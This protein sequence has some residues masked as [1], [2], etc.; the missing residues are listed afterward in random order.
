MLHIKE[1]ES[2]RRH[3]PHSLLSK[4][5]L[6]PPNSNNLKDEEETAAHLSHL[7]TNLSCQCLIDEM[8]DN[9]VQQH[10]NC[11]FLVL[12]ASIQ[13]PVQSIW[14]IYALV[15]SVNWDWIPESVLHCRLRY[16]SYDSI[17]AYSA[18]QSTY[19]MAE[20]KGLHTMRVYHSNSY[21]F[22]A[23]DLW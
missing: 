17:S 19:Y 22:W 20:D 11:H 18:S 4:A 15:F 10:S 8:K 12:P 21:M 7:C 3:E 9:V 5:M 23:S 13:A 16:S 1:E 6:T 14:G 2:F